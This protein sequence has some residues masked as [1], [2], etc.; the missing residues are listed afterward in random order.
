MEQR[1]PLLI[2]DDKEVA[3]SRRQ[4]T[5][6]SV[7]ASL[8]WRS[9]LPRVCVAAM[10]SF[11]VGYHTGVL[12]AALPFVA[13]DLD[14]VED[15]FAQGWVVSISLVGGLLGSMGSGTI[16]DNLGRRRA[17]QLSTIPLIV[18][19]CFSAVGRST[20]LMLLG[21]LLVG[22]GLGIGDSTTTVYVSEISPAQL[23]G[24]FGAM[25]QISGCLGLLGSYVVGLPVATINGWWRLCFWLSLV[26]AAILLLGFECCPESPR[27][28]FKQSRWDEA[29]IAMEKLWGTTNFK[30]DFA[31]LGQGEKTETATYADLCNKEIVKVILKGAAIFVFQQ[32]AGINAIVYFS[33]T[34]FRNAG[35]AS[36]LAASVCVGFVNL[37]VSCITTYLIDRWG[38]K[39]LLMWSFLGMSLGM[40]IQSCAVLLPIANNAKSYVLLF[41]TLFYMLMFAIGAGPVP[42]ALLPEMF[43]NLIRAKAMAICLSVLWITSGLIGMLYLPILELYGDLFLFTFFAIVRL[44]GMIF[45][46]ICI[47]EMRGRSLEEI[48]DSL[49]PDDQKPATPKRMGMLVS[50]GGYGMKSIA[51][52]KAKERPFNTG[53]PLQLPFIDLLPQQP[54]PDRKSYKDYLPNIYTSSASILLLSSHPLCCFALL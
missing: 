38:R 41:G 46:R 26:P 43:P 33:S 8:P 18:G 36:S 20:N 48:E 12:N 15:A 1:V 24:N 2:N 13:R 49:F 17:A 6:E 11:L 50:G 16:A 35:V 7:E 22:V 21:R 28:L 42:M 27:W 54:P 44:S 5:K 52:H 9:C 37:V 14:L 30:A 53:S 31:D 45:V 34:I 25:C 19:G 29:E 51:S 3:A 40:A 4:N 23:R 47:V 39:T 32:F 10:G